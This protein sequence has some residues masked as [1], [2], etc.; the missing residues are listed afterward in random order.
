MRRH[1]QQRAFIR[2]SYRRPVRVL[3]SPAACAFPNMKNK[4]VSPKRRVAHQLEF[5]AT[6]ARQLFPKAF[7]ML[8]L[9][10]KC[11]GDAWGA[12]QLEKSSSFR[13]FKGRIG[14][15]VVRRGRSAPSDAIR[16]GLERPEWHGTVNYPAVRQ[17]GETE[18]DLFAA[19][20]GDVHEN[21]AGI[22]E[23]VF[24]VELRR[25]KDRVRPRKC[26]RKC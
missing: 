2:S 18:F 19:A 24:G 8:D 25:R 21:H 6:Y 5:I 4:N 3:H 1:R 16:A 12:L 13:D 23:G 7:K 10:M 11:H 14:E 20:V 22:D 15:C 9:A 17:I 26:R